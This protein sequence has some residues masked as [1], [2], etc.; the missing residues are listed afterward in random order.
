[1]I[2]CK[3]SGGLGNQLFQYFNAMNVSRN[4]GIA[5]VFLDISSYDKTN[6]HSGYQ[7]DKYGISNIILNK[8]VCKVIDI[9]N[10]LCKKIMKRNL[11]FYHLQDQFNFYD[12]HTNGKFV[13]LDGTFQSERFFDNVLKDVNELMKLELDDKC[14]MFLSNFSKKNIISIHIRRGDYVNNS[15]VNDIIGACSVDYYQEAIDIMENKYQDSEFMIF[16]DDDEW[17]KNNLKFSKAFFFVDF[18]KGSR[19]HYDIELM[20]RCDHHIISN[21]SFSWLGAWS[22][23][24]KNTVI[25]PDPWFNDISLNGEDICPESWIKIK[26]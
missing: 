16:S 20:R 24:K 11:S 19:S 3:L 1:M 6:D 17:Y 14:Q 5:K 13:V 4:L 15:D 18:N 2:I 8:N 26:K 25:C 10:R 23:N 7:L 12:I 9:S 22:E 21:S